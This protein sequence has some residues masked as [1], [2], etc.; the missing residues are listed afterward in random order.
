MVKTIRLVKIMIE[1]ERK[2][3]KKKMKALRVIWGSYPLHIAVVSHCSWSPPPLLPFFFDLLLLLSFQTMRKSF[4]SVYMIQRSKSKQYWKKQPV[5]GDLKYTISENH[6]AFLTH[7]EQDWLDSSPLEYRPL[8]YRRYVDDIFVLFKSSDHLKRFQSYL[9]SCHVS[10][11]FTI[12]TEQENKISF[13]DVSVFFQC[14][15]RYQK[16]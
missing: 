1:T 8:Y 13:L 4:S 15:R 6:N 7:H 16:R 5:T 12:E 10:M 9:N 3:Q 14:W 11:S 2:A